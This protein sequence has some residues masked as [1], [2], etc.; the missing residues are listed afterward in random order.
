MINSPKPTSQRVLKNA[1]ITYDVPIFNKYTTPNG[2]LV[3]DMACQ[4]LFR[5]Y[6]SAS[7]VLDRWEKQITLEG[8][9][10]IPKPNYRG[11]FLTW[12]TCY[13]VAPERMIKFW[14]N[15]DMQCT[16]SEFKHLP[17]TDEIR[18]TTVPEIRSQ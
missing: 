1:Q 13:G 15:V 3:S 17:K 9:R 5:Y 7:D 2:F 8:D 10:D 4:A 18:F 12:A 16:M 11:L 6:L 14:P